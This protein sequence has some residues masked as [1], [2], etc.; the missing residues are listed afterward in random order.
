MHCTYE[1]LYSFV[2]KDSVTGKKQTY[3]G[4]SV[5]NNAGEKPIEDILEVSS[6][7]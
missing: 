4:R 5:I 3:L 6:S 7:R 2:V 1:T